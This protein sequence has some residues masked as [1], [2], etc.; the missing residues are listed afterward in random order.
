MNDRIN[1]RLFKFVSRS[2]NKSLQQRIGKVWICNRIDP[3]SITVEEMFERSVDIR[4]VL[5]GER[6]R[7]SCLGMGLACRS[8][9]LIFP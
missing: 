6:H 2:E 9:Y 4:P 7:K 1:I 8:K 3:G 5:V